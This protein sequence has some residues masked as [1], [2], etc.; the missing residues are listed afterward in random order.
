MSD[1]A[2]RLKFGGQVAA[3]LDSSGKAARTSEGRT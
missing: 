3:P 1:A 2:S